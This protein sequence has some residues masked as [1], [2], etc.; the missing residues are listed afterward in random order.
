MRNV[1][2]TLRHKRF[3]IA[4]AAAERNHYYLA[5][6]GRS[7]GAKEWSEAKDSCGRATA[8]CHSQQIATG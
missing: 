7:Q 2:L 5:A 1:F 4:S 6:V 8:R 3:L